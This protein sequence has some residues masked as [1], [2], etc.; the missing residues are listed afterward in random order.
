MTNLHYATIFKLH[1]HF[2]VNIKFNFSLPR[3]SKDHS[4]AREFTQ[5]HEAQ[6]CFLYLCVAEGQHCTF[7]AQSCR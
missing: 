6:E 3:A 1:N 5:S 2:Q 4:M 7:I